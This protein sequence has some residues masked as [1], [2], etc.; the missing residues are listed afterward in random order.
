MT[1][2]SLVDRYQNSQFFC[3]QVTSLEWWFVF[4]KSLGIAFQKM[5]NLKLT[6]VR[7]SNLIFCAS[8]DGNEI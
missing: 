8:I 3:P 6:A 1:S 4:T 2:C 5:N 7:N